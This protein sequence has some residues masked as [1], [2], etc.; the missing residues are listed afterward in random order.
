MSLFL[1]RCENVFKVVARG[2]LIQFHTSISY[3]FVP[4]EAAAAVMTGDYWEM[5]VLYLSFRLNQGV[6]QN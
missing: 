6:T 2:I 1:L 5:L 4:V 3:C